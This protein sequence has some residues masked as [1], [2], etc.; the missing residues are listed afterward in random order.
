MTTRGSQGI[1]A[2]RGLC[3][4][5]RQGG[6]AAYASGCRQVGDD[7]VTV[8]V[9]PCL[10][11]GAWWRSWR[12]TGRRD[13]SPQPSP[14]RGEGVVGRARQPR[15]AENAPPSPQ[16]MN[17]VQRPALGK[18]WAAKRTKGSNAPWR[19]SGQSPDLAR[20][21]RAPRV[22]MGRSGGFRWRGI[23]TPPRPRRGASRGRVW[24]PSSRSWPTCRVTGNRAGLARQRLC[25]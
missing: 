16:P 10:A 13:P 4:E 15:P 22:V 6:V 3:P 9:G 2:R 25:R 1:Q 7:F 20:L 8:S 11:E 14:S 24:R 21:R 19:V 18:A 5:I 12:S 23:G 17:G